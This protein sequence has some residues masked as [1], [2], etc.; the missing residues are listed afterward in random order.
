MLLIPLM[1]TVNLSREYAG[2]GNYCSYH[3][4]SC[5]HAPTGPLHH[6]PVLHSLS[7]S[8]LYVYT[9][10]VVAILHLQGMASR[11]LSS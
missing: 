10:L 9:V 2:T 5:H 7:L 1:S 3:P 4:Y 8:M 6:L 11:Y